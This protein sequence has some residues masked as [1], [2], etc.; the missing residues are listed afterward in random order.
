MR[1]KLVLRSYG[2]DNRKDRP[3]FYSKDLAL[4][5][6]VRAASALD[7]D[8]Y[9]VNDGP[10]PA[11]RLAVMERFGEVVAIPNGPVGMRGSYV[12]ALDMPDAFGWADDDV[13]S[14][15]E[16]DY[17]FDPEAF[18]TLA[19]AA[20]ALPQASYFAL[21]GSRPADLSDP[22]ERLL[23]GVPR[24]WEPLPDLE[25]HGRTWQNILSVTS[26]FAARVGALRADHDIF[27][28]AM[29]PFR[30]RFLDHETCLLYQGIT[31]YHG[32]EL[33]LGLP[34]ELVPGL[35]GV[36]RTLV[37]VPYRVLLNRRAKAQVDP[38]FLYA[39]RPPLA[40]HLEI[41]MM[42]ERD[43]EAVAAD[44]AQWAA[45]HDIALPAPTR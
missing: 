37:L 7:A 29:K 17:L 31:P 33:L 36:A 4:A 24:E 13:V 28:Q 40:S 23:H 35:R 14:Y 6:F 34:G 39:V 9:F 43:W 12:F 16:D 18:V 44:V 1:C 10:I 27:L 42:G 15:N 38:H 22:A 30:N 8:L 26:T 11:H 32:R 19:Q 41:G 2:G 21:S 3:D 20:E 5:S 45:E 25:A